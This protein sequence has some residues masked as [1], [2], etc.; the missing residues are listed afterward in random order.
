MDWEPRA[1]QL[2]SETV[3]SC[4][5]WSG[6]IVT[7][8]RHVFVPRWWERH[9]DDMALRIGED[10][11]EAWMARVYANETIV[12]RIGPHHA[13]HANP[14][15]HPVG[16]PTSSS[17]LPGLLVQMYRHAMLTEGVK[18]LDV[19]TGTGYGTALLARRFGAEHVT[20]VDVDPYLTEA[21][22]KRLDSIGLYPTVRT[23]DATGDLPGTYDRII[24]TVSV[25]RIPASWLA[26]LRPGGRLVTTIAGTGVIVVAD[27]TE[28]GGAFGHTAPEGAGFMATRHGDDYDD[29]LSKVWDKAKDTDT[30]GEEITTS[31][32]PL[33]FPPDDWA[34]FSM[35]QLTVP[36]I[37]FCKAEED[38][39]RTVWLL[40]EDGSWARATATGF[41]DSP[42]VHQTGPRR[43]WDEFERIRHR[44]NREGTLPVYGATVRITPDGQTTLARGGW[45]VTL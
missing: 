13:D 8:P 33:L 22:S 10:D 40:H 7:T 14:E 29:H 45:S 17:T 23:V 3:H 28:D 18:V 36:G 11:P 21:A 39:T 6:P 1:R 25:R 4:S 44:L 43:L 35:L 24:A 26:A 38:D 19:G 9:G 31:R 30:A 41:L 27:K 37:D 2:A 12:T 32:Y 34:V 20:A 42:K 5:R 15:D 16:L